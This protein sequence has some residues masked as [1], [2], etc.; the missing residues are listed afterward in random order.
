[1][2]PD[3]GGGL[4]GTLSA[5]TSYWPRL[6]REQIRY[7]ASDFDQSRLWSPPAPLPPR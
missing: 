1:V 3:R 5:E 7:G 4:S 6:A 2:V